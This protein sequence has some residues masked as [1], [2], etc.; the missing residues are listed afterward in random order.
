VAGTHDSPAAPLQPPASPR[1]AGSRR[2]QALRLSIRLSHRAGCRPV[3][4]RRRRRLR[5]AGRPRGRL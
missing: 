1:P 2:C 4:L 3:R 5:W